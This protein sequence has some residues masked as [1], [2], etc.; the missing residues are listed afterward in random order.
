MSGFSAD[1]L[2]LREG[3]D[4]RARSVELRDAVGAMFEARSHVEIVDLAC[5]AGSNLRGL[6]SVL[7]AS[8]RWRLVD[9]DPALLEAAR[10]RLAA[11]GDRVESHDPLIILHNG[12]R[13]LVEFRLADLA[14]GAEAVLDERIDLVTAAA[15]FDLVS[16]DWIARFARALATRGAPLYAALTYDGDERW[17]P[18]HAQDAAMLAAFH[19]HQGRDKGFGP[20]AGPRAATILREALEA[21]GYLVSRAASP[22]RLGADDAP[23]IDALADGAAQAVLQTGLSPAET[24]GDWRAQRRSACRIGHVDLLARPPSRAQ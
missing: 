3:A 8:Q 12:R 19:A 17:I 9:H 15:L 18:A 21:R 20:A 14:S 22:W 2:D 16:P 11:W 6:A 24:I 1:W 4:H 13:I 10:S 7:P 5:G 23:L